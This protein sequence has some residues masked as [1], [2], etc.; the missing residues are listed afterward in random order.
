M[1]RV[2]AKHRALGRSLDAR[3][4]SLINAPLP[5]NVV[6]VVNQL[7]APVVGNGASGGAQPSFSPNP[8]PSP[9]G[10]GNGG[11]NGNG[12]GHS[13]GGGSTSA[14]PP[15][16]TSDGGPAATPTSTVPSPVSPNPVPGQ[17]SSASRP[18][19][20]SNRSSMAS[21]SN[22]GGGGN[23]L[24]TTGGQTAAA[25]AAFGPSMTSAALGASAPSA[26]PSDFPSN[27]VSNTAGIV[28]PSPTISAA[29][30]V[31]SG[32][33][34]S[35]GAIAGIIIVGLFFLF[36]LILLVVRR[37]SIAR[38][39]ELRRRWWF[40][41][42]A[43]GH[44]SSLSSGSTRSSMRSNGEVPA[45]RQ[46]ARSSF[47]TNFDHGLMFRIDTPSRLSL[48][49]VP[50][51][52]PKAEVRERNSILISTGGSVARR[53]SMNS[54]LSN[55]SDP[56]AQYLTVST[57]QDNLDPSTP[58][59]V[60]PF[61]PSESFAFP[62]PPPS[63]T[64]DSFF[65][66]GTPGPASPRSSAATLVHLTTPSRAF[67][68]DFPPTISTSLRH[69]TST[70]SLALSPFVTAPNPSL[71]PFA[72]PVRPEFSVVEVIRRPFA[73]TLDDELAVQPGDRVHVFQVFDDGWAFVEGLSSTASERH[74]RGLIPVDC[75]R[76]VNQ[77]LPS[78]LAEKRVSYSDRKV[79]TVL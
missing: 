9:P 29:A 47:A 31:S 66:S 2:S 44:D 42:S 54:M 11:G 75:F 53:E 21:P 48:D 10:G 27:S 76:Q 71:D 73:P 79:A 1:H 46:S 43:L 70:P 16:S 30:A 49:L 62:K 72:D 50:D 39:L 37:H 68:T 13:N 22:T 52:P 28:A 45:S 36:P 78:F 67:M 65:I 12:G 60:R 26:P 8:Q 69:Q 4:P 7:A 40:G 3:G 32:K 59:S 15:S 24:G 34:L 61:S 41:R 25:N 18:N 77:A 17:P 6:P 5:V 51:L 38:R 55:G 74:E 20:G 23:F 64:V 58:M 56:D 19:N 33:R 57:G 63:S 14:L 35:G